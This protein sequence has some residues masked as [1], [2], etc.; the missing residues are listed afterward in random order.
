MTREN[1]I[2][3]LLLATL[4]IN[5]FTWANL[6]EL[7]NELTRVQGEMGSLRS[8]VS[9]EVSGIRGTVESIRDDSRWWTPATMDI[10]AVEKETARLRLSWQ[11]KEYQ[12]GSRV[13]LNY[14]VGNEEFKEVKAQEG[15]RGYFWADL[16][17]G[18][19]EEPVWHINLAQ[20][21]GKGQATSGGSHSV[22][23]VNEHIAG[24]TG[25]ELKYYISV[26]NRGTTLTSEI[27]H[28]ELSK[29]T[30]HLFNTLNAQVRI[31]SNG[32]ITVSLYEHQQFAPH[33]N[34]TALRLESRSNKNVIEQWPLNRNTGGSHNFGHDTAFYETRS[35]PSKQYD[36]L[37]LVAEYSGGL[38]V[39]KELP[40]K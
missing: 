34:L 13:A 31:K 3:T 8:H 10:L 18:M 36:S 4:A 25:A 35:V 20:E 29:L 37:F 17:I 14:K 28:F 33:Y 32:E 7:R 12:V 27:R 2:I 16:T 9:T 38:R 23:V 5:F 22:K 40:I 30:Y 11:L 21:S 6:K 26:A 24:A 1:W 39:E 15:A 19:P